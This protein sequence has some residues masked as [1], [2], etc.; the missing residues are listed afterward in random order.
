MSKTTQKIPDGL[1]PEQIRFCKKAIA[2]GYKIDFTYSGRFMF[3]ARCPSI[4]CDTSSEF[5]FKGSRIDNMGL[6]FVIYMP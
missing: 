6:Q 5:G 3:G 1:R 2:E 4:I